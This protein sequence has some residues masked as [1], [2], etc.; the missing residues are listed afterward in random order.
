MTT[1][2]V[3]LDTL[4]R[5]MLPQFPTDKAAIFYYEKKVKFVFY[6][7]KGNITLKSVLNKLDVLKWYASKTGIKP[8]PEAFNEAMEYLKSN[9]LDKCVR[10]DG[11][12]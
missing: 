5:V 3:S 2:K 4:F 7:S 10:V 1:L 6:A 8:T 12:E 11:E 9:A